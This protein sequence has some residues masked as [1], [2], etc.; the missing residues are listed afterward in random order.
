MK[1]SQ[2]LARHR[3]GLSSVSWVS[4]GA[5]RFPGRALCGRPPDSAGKTSKE[6]VLKYF[7]G[8]RAEEETAASSLRLKAL[9]SFMPENVY[10]VRVETAE[11][12]ITYRYLVGIECGLHQLTKADSA[13]K[14]VQSTFL[15]RY[16]PGRQVTIYNPEPY[17]G[18]EL[19]RLPKVNEVCDC[20]TME[21]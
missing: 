16:T 2:L 13:Q 20:W 15:A 19:P 21:I 14:F 5:K 12:G 1:E 17:E 11:A 8:S 18:D 7:Y 9:V 10:L 3:V 4:S 6:F